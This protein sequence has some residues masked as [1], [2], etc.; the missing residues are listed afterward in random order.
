[1]AGRIIVAFLVDDIRD[2]TLLFSTEDFDK[3]VFGGTFPAGRVLSLTSKPLRTLT[4]LADDVCELKLLLRI[5]EFD[6]GGTGLTRRRLDRARDCSSLTSFSVDGRDTEPSM[7]GDGGSSLIRGACRRLVGVRDGFSAFWSKRTLVR[8]VTF[9]VD[10]RDTESN[11]LLRIVEDEGCR[12]SGLVRGDCRPFV[13]N[14]SPSLTSKPA[15]GV[16]RRL[17]LS[18]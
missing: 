1:M 14:C 3:G 11:L 16:E 12:G 17:S 9:S 2:P 5:G 7:F 18:S 8:L 13:W 4:F 15:L 10:G 6:S